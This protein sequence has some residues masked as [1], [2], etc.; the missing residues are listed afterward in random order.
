M[1]TVKDLKEYLQN[2]IDNLEEYE[3]ETQLKIVENTYWLK[4]GQNF[5]AI[6]GQG[7]VDLD[8]PTDL[9]ECEWC[10]DKFD[11]TELVKTREFGCLCEQCFAYLES[12]GEKLTEED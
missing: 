10:G 8:N 4:D 2:I 7:F 5:I 3:E 9:E 6:E 1:E 11:K 12:V